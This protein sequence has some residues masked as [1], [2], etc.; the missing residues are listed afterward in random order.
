MQDGKFHSEYS[1]AQGQ[2]MIYRFDVH[3]GFD[4]T[5]DQLTMAYSVR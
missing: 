2:K 4:E 3:I 1:T 5:I